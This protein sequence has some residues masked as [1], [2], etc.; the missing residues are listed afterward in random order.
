[1]RSSQSTR[2]C[3]SSGVCV[4][5][6]LASNDIARGNT[7]GNFGACGCGGDHKICPDP[8]WQWTAESTHKRKLQEAGAQTLK[9]DSSV[10]S[11]T[12]PLIQTDV[13]LISVLQQRGIRPMTPEA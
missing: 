8:T 11:L 13:A 2:T 12:I 9:L 3:G 10:N 4:K 6:C 5:C 7:Q 1:M